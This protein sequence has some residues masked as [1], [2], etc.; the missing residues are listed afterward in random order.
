MIKREQ[1]FKKDTTRVNENITAKS[2]RLVDDSGEMIGVVSVDEALEKAKSLS[3]D[4]VEIS[5]NA[6]PPVCKIIDYGKFSYKQEKKKKEAKERRIREAHYSQKYI[7]DKVCMDG[8]TS[9]IF[10]ITVKAY[11]EEINGDNMKIRIS[12]TEGTSPKYSG[13]TLYKDTVI[14]DNVSNWYKCS[15]L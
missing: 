13:Q 4:L 14:W 10:S 12:D 5:P 1:Y 7:G 11:V 3:L 15:M 9:F 8:I 2:V 6:D